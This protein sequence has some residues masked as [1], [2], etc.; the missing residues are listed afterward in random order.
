MESIPRPPPQWSRGPDAAP[1][2]APFVSRVL[3]SKKVRTEVIDPGPP[4]I[5]LRT[6]GRR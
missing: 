3:R 2:G 6:L 4:R 5:S 1:H